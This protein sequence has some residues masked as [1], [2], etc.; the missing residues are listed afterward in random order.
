MAREA[1]AR[2]AEERAADALEERMLRAAEPEAAAA[3]A[4]PAAVSPP[5]RRLLRWRRLPP[6]SRRPAAAVV[7]RAGVAIEV[8]VARV[9]A[10]PVA[11]K[12]AP[13]ILH[14]P[15]P[16]ARRRDEGKA[17]A[18]QPEAFSLASGRPAGP[19]SADTHV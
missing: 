6:G 18:R 10:Q 3:P 8:D 9:P 5:R 16:A 13:V 15:K 4:A 1:D 12:P 19:L 14:F 11:A 17:R 7:P 2:E